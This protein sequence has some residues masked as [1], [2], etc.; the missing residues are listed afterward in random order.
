MPHPH[1]S[2]VAVLLALF[3]PALTAL[4]AHAASLDETS[5]LKANNVWVVVDDASGT[6]KGGCATNFATGLDALTSAGFTPSGGAFVCQIDNVPSTCSFRPQWWSYWH[7]YNSPDGWGT[8]QFSNEGAADHQPIAGSVEGWHLVPDTQFNGAPPAHMPPPIPL[9]PAAGTT[10]EIPDAGLRTCLAGAAHAPADAPLTDRQLAEIT[11]LD[12]FHSGIVDLT[13]IEHVVNA[14]TIKLEMNKITN[15]AP[16]ASLAKL[17]TL[18]LDTNNIAD[19]SGLSGMKQLTTLDLDNNQLTSLVPLGSLTGLQT[20]SL[21]GQ[22]V[23]KDAPTLASAAGLETLTSLR[24]LDISSNAISDLTPISGLELTRLLAFSNKLDGL[25]PLSQMTTLTEL[26]LHTNGLTDVSDLAP[27]ANL[28]ILNLRNNSLTDVTSLT[29]LPVLADLELGNN[30]GLTNHAALGRIGTLTRLG[31]DSTGLTDAGFL[32]SLPQLTA[33]YAHGNHVTDLSPLKGHELASWGVTRQTATRTVEA[34]T[35]VHLTVLDQTGAP[36]KVTGPDGELVTGPVTF[37]EPG[38]YAYSFAET[39]SGS[40]YGKFT[41]KI[42]VV[43]TPKAVVSPTPTP[44]PVA[45]ATPA[46]TTIQTPPT[47]PDPAP[48]ATP[49]PTAGPTPSEATT[50]APAPAPGV[51]SLPHTGGPALSLTALGLTAAAI[52]GGALA[53]RRR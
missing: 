23:T 41:G 4:P 30:P 29:T 17:T 8:W 7:L 20:L 15:P 19:A 43:V 31:M 24:D 49:E 45:T 26:N 27:L 28:T 51:A 3:S 32:T 36:A 22:K 34:G 37:T 35:P 11:T 6:V 16:L 25:A 1:V 48:I 47:T 21:R 44:T 53:R 46:P 10:V 52:G 40:R 38:E 18:D 9:A 12:C 42:T 5:C 2:T 14:T 33:F 39:S 50:P 13:G